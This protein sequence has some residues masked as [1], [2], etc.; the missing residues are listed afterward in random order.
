MKN[1]GS[2]IFWLLLL[3]FLIGVFLFQYNTPKQF[4]WEPTYSTYDKQPFGSYVFDDVVSSSVKDYS[5]VNKTFYQLY[6]ECEDEW[7][8]YEEEDYAEYDEYDEPDINDEEDF[9]IPI[10]EEERR[11]FLLTEQSVSFSEIDVDA[12]LKLVKQGNKIMLCLSSFPY[13]LCDSLC[14][15]TKSD[16]YLSLRFIE[17]YAK[18]GNLR[19]SL[20]LGTDTIKPKQIYAVYPHLHPIYIKE[21]REYLSWE[22]QDSIQKTDKIRCDSLETLVYNKNNQPV[23]MRLFIGKG[24]LFL[25]STP[26]MFTNYGILDQNNASYAFQLLSYLKE[27]PLVRLEAYGVNNQPSGSPFRY[28]LSQPTLR[29]ALYMAFMLIIVFM[30][31]TAKRR[32]RI[33][34]VVRQPVNQAMRF[35]QLIGNLYYQKKN[36]KDL[37]QK[38]YL[39]FCAEVKRLNGLDLQSDEPNEE[40][41]RRLSDKMGLS[42]D[43][44][45]PGFRELKY[46]LRPETLVDESQMIRNIDRIN[47]WIKYL[48]N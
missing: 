30:I 3:A 27:M 22:K 23:V 38:K 14:F 35:T 44:V 43:E 20:F 4:V 2:L 12:L 15:T 37:V 5:L 41:C 26:L 42:I 7:Y 39:Y 13:E 8:D 33:I 17:R 45:W 9:I 31:F 29:W 6:Q 24:E 48:Y 28:L 36:Y 1:K 46:L 34:P 16:S 47:Q 11:G 21:G 18:E 25:V 32:Q 40:L 10:S 19:D